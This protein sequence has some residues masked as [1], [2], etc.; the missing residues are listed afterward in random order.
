VLVVWQ[1]AVVVRG[2][3][4]AQYGDE[5]LLLAGMAG[6]AVRAAA[7][8]RFTR[9]PLDVP[10]VCLGVIGVIAGV[11]RGVPPVVVALGLLAVLK[12]PLAFALVARVRV[13]RPAV[14]RA[15]P[16]L[17]AMVAV[18][19]AIG[20][21]QRAGGA[22]IYA[23]T[24]S[25]TEYAR[26]QGA[27]APSLFYN[28]N[29]LGHV[30]VLAGVLATALAWTET[31]PH[32]RRRLVIVALACLAGLVVSASRESWL[33]AAAALVAGA[34]V[35]R[36]RA[37][38]R[39]AVVTALVLAAGAVLVY[40]G[41]P[42]L[43]AELAR[44][45]AGVAEGW[46]VWALGL[47]DRAFRGEY[48]VYVAL[49]SAEIWRDHFWLGTGPGRYGGQVALRYLSPIYAQYRFLPLDGT[50][51]PLDMFWAR[52]L[53]EFGLLGSICYGGLLAVVARVHLAGRH[54][55][56]AMTRGLAVGGWMAL[57]AALVFGFF[58]PALEDP[59]VAIP[60]FAWGGLVWRLTR[61]PAPDLAGCDGDGP[62]L[63]AESG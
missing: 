48:R 51:A 21:L 7:T 57:V 4:I 49:K 61:R 10:L 32:R 41:D 62:T 23:L 56:D 28:H 60:L 58:A 25:M 9:T 8:R 20:V 45:G 63:A 1:D 18:L 5:A 27:K 14:A 52:L 16:V 17:L 35:T 34:W 31:G 59:L 22:P 42:L 11:V 46:H 29:A 13:E 50:F 6:L 15:I 55:P 26:W 24:G 3:A 44:R 39:L 53:A 54:A 2:L 12:G 33:A 40:L 19:A 43:R 37:I 36:S 47:R 30:C 38:L